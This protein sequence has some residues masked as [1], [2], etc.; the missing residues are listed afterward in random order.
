[1]KTLKIIP[2]LDGMSV[3]YKT[4][5]TCCC[6]VFNTATAYPGVRFDGSTSELCTSKLHNGDAPIYHILSRSTIINKERHV[7]KSNIS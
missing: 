6:N 4:Y 5:T 1:M 2:L 7:K 3:E